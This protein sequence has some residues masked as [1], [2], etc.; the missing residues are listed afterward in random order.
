[1]SVWF[2]YVFNPFLF[3]GLTEC[4][5]V[6][7]ILAELE[8]IRSVLVKP[9]VDLPLTE[10]L[11]TK[12]EWTKEEKNEEMEYVHIPQWDIVDEDFEAFPNFP[13]FTEQTEIKT[14]G[15]YFDFLDFKEKNAVIFYVSV[16]F[17]CLVFLG[18][19]GL[20]VW[21]CIRKCKK[22]KKMLVIEHP[23]FEESNE[24][25][26]SSTPLRNI[27]PMDVAIANA[28]ERSSMSSMS[29]SAFLEPKDLPIPT[30]RTSKSQTTEL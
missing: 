6:K 4:I 22:E 16:V 25:C 11:E 8:T 26:E 13:T 27:T 5:G 17:G 28:E 30:L 9:V 14:S 23:H 24:V 19:F 1:M 12:K 7:E 2:L 3:S 20:L 10:H 29:L 21:F 15:F 18:C